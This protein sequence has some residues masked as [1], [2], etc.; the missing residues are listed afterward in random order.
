ME[1]RFWSIRPERD[2][3]HQ[4]ITIL[5]EIMLERYIAHSKSSPSVTFSLFC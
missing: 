2:P 5:S 3:K 1:L 4:N